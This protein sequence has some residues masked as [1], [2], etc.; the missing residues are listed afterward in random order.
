MKS[1]SMSLARAVGDFVAHLRG[2]RRA[3]EH[4]VLA[5]RRDLDQLVAFL[6]LRLGRTPALADVNKPELRAWLAQ[7]HRTQRGST[8]ARKLN[9]HCAAVSLA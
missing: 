8:L 5:Y 1:A 3:S 6:E 9:V 2:E 7:L 4:T